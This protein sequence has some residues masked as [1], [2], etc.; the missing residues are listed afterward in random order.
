MSWRR[1]T[2]RNSDIH[3]YKIQ[4]DSTQHNTTQ[5]NDTQYN[6]AQYNDTQYDAA[7]FNDTQYANTRCYADYRLCLSVVNCM[8]VVIPDSYHIYT[9]AIAP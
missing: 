4:N 2:Q 8:D 5:Y 9:F 1:E 6:D 3:H 7:Q